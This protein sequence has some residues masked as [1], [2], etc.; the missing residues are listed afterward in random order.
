MIE[1]SDRLSDG[2]VRGPGTNR[3]TVT[4]CIWG[5]IAGLAGLIWLGTLDP[6][7]GLP[8][9]HPIN[10]TVLGVCGMIGMEFTGV[11]WLGRSRS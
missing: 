7:I 8:L 11:I 2:P 4:F 3:V 10:L 9:T 5:I 1:P 6:F